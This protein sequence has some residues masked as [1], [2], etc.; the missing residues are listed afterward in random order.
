MR[1]ECRAVSALGSDDW[2]RWQA[3]VDAS[4]D[5]ASPFFA[6][7]FCRLVARHSQDLEVAL[8]QDGDG[9]GYF[10]FHRGRFD[11]GRP[12]AKGLSDYHGVVGRAGAGIDPR[13][14]LRACRLAAFEFDHIP[15]VQ[16]AFAPFAR[17][18]DGSPV[19]DL[20][21]GFTTYAARLAEKSDVL[22][23]AAAARRRLERDHGPVVIELESADEVQLATLFALKSAQYRRTGRRDV[24]S[25]P[26]AR[27]VLTSVFRTRERQF[28]GVLSVLRAGA[29]TLA[30]H[31][32]MRSAKV[33][34]YWF[35]AYDREYAQ[36]SPG[37]IL[38][39]AL[40]QMAP[41]LG[42]ETIDLG[43]GEADY[44]QRFATGAVQLLEGRIE[45]PS[46]LALWRTARRVWRRTGAS[47]M[48]RRWRRGTGA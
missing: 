32:G 39:A 22:A 48:V 46:L 8:I 15:A 35:P 12:L 11:G 14:L 30:L 16:T 26:W 45:R 29:R 42:I 23:R 36:Y 41:A 4:P 44:K 5:L 25:D 13:A 6:P 7:T 34:H 33:L 19:M 24:V 47:A 28:A 37:V 21:G 31:L 10:P 20:A 1:I 18:A 40:A 9:T 17:R 43:K 3:I 2:D 27:A 38:L